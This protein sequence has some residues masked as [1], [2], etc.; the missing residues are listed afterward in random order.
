MS[1]KVYLA[2]MTTKNQVVIPK[3]IREILGLK[4]GD[5]VAFILEGETVRI[6]KAEIKV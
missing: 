5:Y 3:E 2:K 4:P 6:K 1:E